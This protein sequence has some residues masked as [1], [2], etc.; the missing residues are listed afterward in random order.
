[1]LTDPSFAVSLTVNDCPPTSVN[2]S[3]MFIAPSLEMISYPSSSAP[4]HLSAFATSSVC[5]CHVT[6]LPLPRHLSAS[7]TPSVCLCHVICLPLPPPVP[8]HCCSPVIV[9]SSPEAEFL[10]VV[11]TKVLLF[12]V[13]STNGSNSPPHV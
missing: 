12:T 4:R 6:C 10:S 2:S 13:A 7:A 8:Q 9:N 1:M 5:L 3:N 11:G